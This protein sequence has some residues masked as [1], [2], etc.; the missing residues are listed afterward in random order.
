MTDWGKGYSQRFEFC[1]VDPYTWNDRRP[2]ETVAS[3]SVTRDT[4]TALR[5]RA[6][7]EMDSIDPGEFWVR[8]YMT[9]TQGGASQR[10]A[11]GTWLVQTPSV[12]YGSGVSTVRCQAYSSLHPL[13]ESLAPIGYFVRE[14]ANVPDVVAGIVGSVST[15]PFIVPAGE[16]RLPSHYV[17]SDTSSMLDVCRGIAA[18]VGLRV[19]FDA[20]GRITLAPATP[21]SSLV[22]SWVFRDDD[23]SIM[24]PDVGVAEDWFGMP[25]VCEVVYTKRGV[26]TVGRAVNDNP[27]SVLS[28]V[29][30][31]R[32][33]TLRVRNPRELKGAVTERACELL[34]RQRLQEASMLERTVTLEHGWCPVGIG[35]CVRME[36]SRHGLGIEGIIE[37]QDFDL[38]TGMTVKSVITTR[39][40]L[41]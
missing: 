9:V 5:E 7:I 10:F 27:E 24:M 6:T 13:S 16:F 37:R 2:L 41:F 40:N 28:T 17:A 32:E 19:G 14:G 1:E 20:F 25:N 31:G 34:A 11:V 36:Y 23:K 21:V 15:V 29:R 18:A 3:C 8:A 30:R 39:S 22:P 33:V 38:K 12:D 4:D 35:D 26:S